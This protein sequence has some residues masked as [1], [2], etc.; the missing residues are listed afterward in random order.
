VR[1]F[2][3]ER[4]EEPLDLAVPARGA[5]WDQDVPGAELGEGVAKLGAAGVAERVV[6]HDGLHRAA[7]LLA[8]PRSG[9][10][11]G[12]RDGVRVLG[13]VDLAVGQAGVVVDDAD[14][15]DPAG[16]A[17]AVHLRAVAV[18]PVPTTS[19]LGSSKASM[20]SSAP[21]SVHS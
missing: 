19:N 5:R 7:A 6:A 10:A 1:P 12:R 2:G 8:H 9:A 13:G 17:G 20:C 3:V 4:S 16:V 11:Q 15:L 14:D 18:R 21:A